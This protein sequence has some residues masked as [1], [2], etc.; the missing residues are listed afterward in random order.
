M[1][2]ILSVLCLITIAA[3]I[4]SCDN[5]S[6]GGTSGGRGDYPEVSFVKEGSG[7]NAH[8]ICYN[9][10]N[11][12]ITTHQTCTW[13]CATYHSTTP[14]FV[15]LTFDQALV[16]VP[17]GATDPDTGLPTETCSIEFSLTNEQFGACVL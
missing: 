5:G 8:A 12:V 6:S 10:D 2:S 1:K 14:R 7:D 13:N 9:A 11:S 4:T 3:F 15:Q 16:C 17:T